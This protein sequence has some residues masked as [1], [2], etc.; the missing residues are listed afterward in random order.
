MKWYTYLICFILIVVGTFCGIQLYKEVK[1]ESY[2]NGSI[3]ISNQFSQES[4]NYSSTSLVFY[5]DGYSDDF[6]FDKELL[7]VDNFNGKDKEYQVLLNDYILIDSDINSGFVFSVVNIDFYDTNG[8]IVC[9]SS[10][11]ISIKFLSNKTQLTI[12]TVGNKNA[13]YLE[14]Y[15]SDN[16]IRLQ[17]IEIL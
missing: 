7:K 17:V 8:E 5:N 3:D 11:N 12:T 10:M 1:A 6:I 13:S 14:Q 9:T 16:G 2:I 4:F 15:F